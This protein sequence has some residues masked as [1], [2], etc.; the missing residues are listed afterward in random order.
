MSPAVQTFPVASARMYSWSPSLTAAW[1][2]LLEWVS[3]RAGVSLEVL[4]LADPVSLDDLW[5]R[6]DLG[7]APVVTR[8]QG[9]E[10]LR[11]SL[12]EAESERE[13][14][15]SRSA[16]LEGE[17]ESTRGRSSELE[18]ELERTRARSSGSL[19]GFEM[20]SSAPT[21]RPLMRLLVS[22]SAVTSTTGIRR[23][24]GSSL[25]Q[26]QASKPSSLGI[27]T[28]IKMTSGCS[29]AIASSASWPSWA[30]RSR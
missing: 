23:V 3:A 12:T 13:Q 24:V 5:A 21:S 19:N 4:N 6:E 8:E 2:R 27:R 11:A 25:M 22:A 20:K 10:E 26:R 15:R 29:T 9:L 18:S 1:Q 7:Y 17:L 28:S 16:E 14:L 30:I